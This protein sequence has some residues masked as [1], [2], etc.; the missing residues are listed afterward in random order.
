MDHVT[1]KALAAELGLDRSNM[2]KYTLKC[3][4]E[5]VRVRTPDSRGQETLAV[6]PEDA[7]KIRRQRQE[8]G[9]D[10]S[11]AVT[12]SEWGYFYAIQV[13]PEFDP[14]RIKFGYTNDVTAR[15]ATH[16]TSAPTAEVLKAWPCRARWE[17]TA[18]DALTSEGCGQI[19][20]E[21]Y[22][23]DDPETVVTRGDAF[24]ALL[25]ARPIPSAANMVYG[26]PTPGTVRVTATI[27][28]R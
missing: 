18:I 7:E 14:K 8:D 11:R 2:R 19:L 28:P 16:R 4:V 5:P 15:L 20:N 26:T 13:I 10:G 9:F 1:L 21:V 23:V 27:A 24:F 25:P 17:Q 3:G 12:S 6:S 22:E